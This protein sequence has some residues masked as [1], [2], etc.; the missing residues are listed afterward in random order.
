[1]GPRRLSRGG[2]MARLG[3]VTALA[4]SLLCTAAGAQDKPDS[5]APKNE[6]PPDVARLIDTWLDAEQGY[7]K[8]PSMVV[9][10]VKGD[11]IVFSKGY[12]S[13][14]GKGGRPATADTVYS[15]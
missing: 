14:D 5:P 11:A 15:I 9:G 13:V 10:V 7:K 8:L 6:L 12:G 2:A 3:I 4:C 1:M